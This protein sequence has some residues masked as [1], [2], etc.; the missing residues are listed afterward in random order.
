MGSRGGR[1]SGERRRAQKNMQML[2]YTFLNKKI[3]NRD[4]AS[5]LKEMGFKGEDLNNGLA[6]IHAMYKAV[7]D[8]NP[9]AFTAL[10]ELLGKELATGKGEETLD[11][12][13]VI[14]FADNGATKDG[15]AD[16]LTALTEDDGE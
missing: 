7:L 13:I 10:M 5:E 15:A 9:K 11:N 6:L 2:L 3:S 4:I 14:E 12:R 16:D 1:I 8:G